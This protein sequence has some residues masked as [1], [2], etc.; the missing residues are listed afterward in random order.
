[1]AVIAS[2]GVTV[3]R[4]LALRSRNVAC[5]DVTEIV[6]DGGLRFAFRGTQPRARNRVM[7]RGRRTV[8]AMQSVPRA[9]LHGPT[10]V[11]VS[12]EAEDGRVL[13]VGA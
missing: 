1:M 9:T 11:Y 10:E 5:A 8:C 2:A 6:V 12:H 3:R 7:R 13:A 4:A